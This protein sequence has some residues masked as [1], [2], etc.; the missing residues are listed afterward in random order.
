MTRRPAMA[1]VAASPR[2]R[3]PAEV[4][5]AGDQPEKGGHD[6][7]E[8]APGQAEAG[9]ADGPTAGLAVPEPPGAASARSSVPA[10]G[11]AR[12]PRYRVASTPSVLP[13]FRP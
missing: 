9:L 2:Q 4:V 1:L 11:R 12:A 10:A 13:P 5:A 6:R 8:Q 3:H 7:D